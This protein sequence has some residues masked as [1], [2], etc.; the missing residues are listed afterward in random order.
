MSKQQFWILNIVGGVCALLIA[1]NLTL[2]QLDVRLNKMVV[3]RQNQFENA[4]RL[5]N[6]AQ[7]LIMRIAQ[8]GQGDPALTQLLIRHDFK[9][10]LNTTNAQAT[11]TP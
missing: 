4:Q 8:A 9:I 2:A 10:N 1:I 5:R 3:G 6:T 11:P 7:G